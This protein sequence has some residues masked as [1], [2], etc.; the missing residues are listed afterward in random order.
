MV[1]SSPRSTARAY[2]VPPP[3]FYGDLERITEQASNGDFSGLKDML[4]QL[5]EHQRI[6]NE[7]V[8]LLMDGKDNSTGTVTLTTSSTTTTLVD[9]RIG[10]TTKIILVP[11]SAAALADTPWVTHPNATEG[12]ATLNHASSGTTRS[13]AYILRG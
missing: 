11:L 4:W 10:A 12:Q 7:A 13:F 9:A 2:R 3:A 8:E 1:L 5:A 6:V